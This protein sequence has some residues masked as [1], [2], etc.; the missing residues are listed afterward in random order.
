MRA[1]LAVRS[2]NN[3]K[4]WQ[5]A[6]KLKPLSAWLNALREAVRMVDECDAQASGVKSF[7]EAVTKF[8]AK[9]R[10]PKPDKK[11]E[12]KMNNNAFWTRCA[13]FSQSCSILDDGAQA[14]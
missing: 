6:K 1:R 14:G 9:I 3:V 7:D 12:K 11:E 4:L 10:Y 8:V 2:T 13:V 5:D